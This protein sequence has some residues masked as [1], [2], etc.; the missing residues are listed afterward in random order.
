[1]KQLIIR[2]YFKYKYNHEK[3]GEYY[4]KH[5]LLSVTNDQWWLWF[6]KFHRIYIPDWINQLNE[7]TPVI[8]QICWIVS[9]N[10]LM[11]VRPGILYRKWTNLHD[12][13]R[14]GWSH[15]TGQMWP[16]GFSLKI[17][18]LD[19]Q[20]HHVF[21][22]EFLPIS[23]FFYYITEYLNKQIYNLIKIWECT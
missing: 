11:C 15:P 4:E 8:R 19:C 13:W 2:S 5:S 1:M 16:T 21:F 22:N 18:A 7:F 9:V 17:H 3:L 23:D 12:I 20:D 14:A 6:F 10:L